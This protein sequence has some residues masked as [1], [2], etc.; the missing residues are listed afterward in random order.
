MAT[1]PPNIEDH[2]RLLVGSSVFTLAEGRENRVLAV[3]HGGVTVGTDKS[4]DG[5]RVPLD[6]LRNAAT[7][8]FRDGEV[9]VSVASLGH[10]SS[11]LGAFLATLSNVETA[12]DPLRLM[13]TATRPPVVPEHVRRQ[14]LW[15]SLAPQWPDRADALAQSVRAA[16]IY[17]TGR[18]IFVDV[19][20][21]R[22]STGDPR[23]ATV[24]I[25]HTGRSYPDDISEKGIR[26][27]YPETQRPSTDRMEVLATKAAGELGLPIFVVLEGEWDGI[28]A[29]SVPN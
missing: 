6:D 11:F 29:F 25:R 23:G 9:Q 10:R 15:E 24:S 17:N 18:G 26:Y 20:R 5:E 2:A 4:P 7:R 19:V 3:D 27:H 22:V 21:T 16:G 13:V 8:L 12:T 28:G 1:G 14:R